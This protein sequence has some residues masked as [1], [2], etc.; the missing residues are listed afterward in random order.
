[1]NKKIEFDYDGEHY[2]L[3]YD[4]A[5][6]NYMEAKGFVLE[7]FQSKPSTMLGLAWEGAFVKNHKKEKVGKVNELFDLIGNRDELYPA[8]SE[9]IEETYKFILEGDENSKKIEW[10]I[11]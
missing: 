5:S 4:R 3:E 8:L 6:I 10:K 7:Q 9:M 1:M 2:V 11:S